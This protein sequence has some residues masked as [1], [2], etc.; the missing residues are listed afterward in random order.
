MS[1]ILPVTQPFTL[2][3]TG[4]IKL[5]ASKVEG[6]GQSFG[7]ILKG[8]LSDT[9]DLQNNAASVAQQF[10]MGEISDVHDV[11][12]AAE[13]AGVSFELVMEIRNKLIDAYQEFMRMQV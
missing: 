2:P 7:Q 11:M 5:P 10:S 6:D 4:A 13:K 12:I 1:R 8:M 3:D 9:N